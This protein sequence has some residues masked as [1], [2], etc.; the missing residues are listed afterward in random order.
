MGL[1]NQFPFTNFHEANL[2]WLITN[3]NNIPNTI[4]N[5]LNNDEDVRNMISTIIGNYELLRTVTSYGADN[6][7]ATDSTAAFTAAANDGVI[8][9]DDGRFTLL[10]DVNINVPVIFLGNGILNV[11]GNSRFANIVAPRRKIFDIVSPKIENFVMPEWFS[12]G[13]IQ[14][15]INSLTRGTISLK[16]GG[17]TGIVDGIRRGDKNAYNETNINITK[18]NITIEGNG[19]CIFSENGNAFTIGDGSTH[20]EY[21]TINNCTIVCN[22][23]LTNNKA[24]YIN[25]A[26]RIFLNNIRTLGAFTALKCNNT[27]N[28][29]GN[30]IIAQADNAINGDRALFDISSNVGQN[31]SIYLSECIA[32]YQSDSTISGETAFRIAGSDIKDVFITNCEVAYAANGMIIDGNSSTGKGNIQI[33]GFIADR[34]RSAGI[35]IRN[36]TD[37]G[38]NI[39]ISDSWVCAGGVCYQLNNANNV[40][41]VNSTAFDMKNTANGFYI[42][43]NRN[44]IVS[45]MAIGC[46]TGCTIDASSKYNNVGFFA[47]DSWPA[48]YQPVTNPKYYGAVTSIGDYNSVSFCN[49]PDGTYNGVNLNGSH[50]V[51][52]YNKSCNNNGTN[53]HV[54]DY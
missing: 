26:E 40:S 27:I 12:D 17:F 43:G 22:R 3:V 19:A 4:E 34:I 31:A 13:K 11:T 23:Q 46:T 14:T 47:L 28:V 16:S 41:I 5:I 6:T 52:E 45:C 37:K 2:D 9:V 18:S 30:K 24:I 8:I 54:Y 42:T 35:S 50:C 1:F 33:R 21:V 25:K 38:S 39:Q 29:F 10:S 44:R 15:A 49:W 20:V 51:S 7:G 36:M 32:N 48:E 53:N